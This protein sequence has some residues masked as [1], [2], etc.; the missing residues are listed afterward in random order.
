MFKLTMKALMKGSFTVVLRSFLN[1]P[2]FDISI[3][4][5]P[6]SIS[7]ASVLFSVSAFLKPWCESDIQES[8]NGWLTYHQVKDVGSPSFYHHFSFSL[9]ASQMCYKK[10]DSN[11][12]NCTASKQK[13]QNKLPS[14]LWTDFQPYLQWRNF[15]GD[16]RP[17]KREKGEEAG[18]LNQ[19]S[20]WLLIL[21]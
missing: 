10:Q 3:N 7:S 20:I 1:H 16:L 14:A 2:L 8:I 19:L 18:W 9:K 13:L 17:I 4:I 11:G 12:W 21:A 5:T 15:L 6:V